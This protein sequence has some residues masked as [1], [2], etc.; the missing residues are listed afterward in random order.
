V[1]KGK[2]TLLALALA[3]MAAAPVSS[4]SKDWRDWFQPPTKPAASEPGPK[5]PELTRYLEDPRL[6]IILSLPEGWAVSQRRDNP[7]LFTSAPDSG[8]N[9]PLAS[10]VIEPLSSTM[11]PYNYL[12]ANILSLQ[13]SIP[14]LR[15]QKWAV[16]IIDNRT[17]AWI[18]YTYPF[19]GEQVEAVAYCQTQ[20]NKAYV[21]TGMAPAPQF[22]A[23]EGLLRAI[24]R[25]LKIK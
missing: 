1:K 18:H 6:G 21:V 16:E 3:S 14:Q 12:A 9:G 11:D 4:C 25:S 7:M 5:L 17:V 24:G 15:I 10:L 19:R 22:A 23:N 13:A 8:P 2:G 20:G